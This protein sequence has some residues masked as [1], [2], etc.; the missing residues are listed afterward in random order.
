[1]IKL[2]TLEVWGIEGAI[3]GMR[4]PYKNRDK[5]DS[6]WEFK[7]PEAK[8]SIFNYVI[9]P[10]DLDLAQRLLSTRSD[11]DSKFM[12]MIHVQVDICAPLY[13]WKEMDQ[14]KIATTT[15]SESTMHTIH[16][17]SF[18]LDDFSHDMLFDE[19]VV[20]EDKWEDEDG[21]LPLYPEELLNDTI[22]VLNRLRDKYIHYKNNKSEIPDA[23]E[24]MKLYWYNMIQ[25]LPSSYM[26][27]RTVDFNYQTIRRIFFA[28]RHHKLKEWHEFCDW[29]MSLPY[30]EELIAYDHRAVLKTKGEIE[31]DKWAK[32]LNDII[33]S[34][35][36]SD[37]NWND[38]D[39][40]IEDMD[41]VNKFLVYI[42]QSTHVYPKSI[43]QKAQ[44]LGIDALLTRYGLA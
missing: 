33:N 9:G 10:K 5:S 3:Q 24:Q 42:S 39:Q 21:N 30:A 38:T 17:R 7:N 32:K 13:W 40:V 27:L 31:R 43:E 28:R 36:I 26:Q 34:G 1:M 37:K 22:D 19:Y 15:N 41:N 29:V 44:E 35:K 18:G 14:Y 8:D 25:L 6:G 11:D 20:S 2:E 16:S 23:E 12:R 4:N